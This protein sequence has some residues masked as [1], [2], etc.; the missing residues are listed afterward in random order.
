MRRTNRDLIL[1]THLCRLTSKTDFHLHWAKSHFVRSRANNQIFNDLSKDEFT[2][3]EMYYY[4]NFKLI[5]HRS[6]TKTYQNCPGHWASKWPTSLQSITLYRELICVGYTWFLNKQRIPLVFFSSRHQTDRQY[7][8]IV[9]SSIDWS[10]WF[11]ESWKYDK[12]YD[13][14]PIDIQQSTQ[15]QQFLIL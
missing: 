15:Q 9:T 8:K 5:S 3:L 4:Q 11:F 6:Q 1:W 14:Y 2:E 10:F 13:Y 7:Y 12:L